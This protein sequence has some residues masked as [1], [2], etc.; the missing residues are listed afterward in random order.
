VQEDED[1]KRELYILKD[2]LQNI[3][4]KIALGSESTANHA[5][6]LNAK[7]Q[8]LDKL[9]SLKGEFETLINMCD[10]VSESKG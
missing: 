3:E 10:R 9:R 1:T 8:M 6:D 4:S 7:L 5:E 2:K